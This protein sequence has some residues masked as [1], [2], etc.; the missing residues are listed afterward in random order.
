MSVA[1][2]QPTS[3]RQ[4]RPFALYWL[5][6]VASTVAMQMQAVA[7]AWQMYEITHNPLDLGLVG[8]H[9]VHPGRAV[10]AGRGPRRRPLRPAH[11]RAHLPDDLGACG[12]HARHRHRRRLDDAG[13]AARRRVRDRL[14]ARLRADHADH[15]AAGDRA[16]VAVVAR[17]GGGRVGD[18][19][20][21][22]RRAGDGRLSLCGEPD[23]GLCAVLH[24]L[25]HIELPDRHGQGRAQCEL[26][27]TH[28]SCRSVR[29]ISL[30]PAQ[31]GHSRNDH[32]RSVRCRD[33][34]R[35]CPAAGVRP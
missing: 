28:Q 33:R 5:S 11:D 29:R 13:I 9:P 7:V 3:L 18:A 12:G 25:H 30:H 8:P 22:D 21:N 20:R 19:D 4:H 10:R 23:P 6:R 1:D 27:R 24:A 26:A 31:S 16:A 17:D 35:L 14:G 2:A 32:A 34:R 15:A